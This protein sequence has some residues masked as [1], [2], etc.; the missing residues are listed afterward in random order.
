MMVMMMIKDDD[1]GVSLQWMVMIPTQAE[2]PFCITK[3]TRHTSG[4]RICIACR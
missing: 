1:Q 2:F 4:C 3:T